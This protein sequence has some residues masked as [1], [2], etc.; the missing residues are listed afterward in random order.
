MNIFARYLPI[1]RFTTFMHPSL[2][3]L[4]AHTRLILLVQLLCLCGMGVVGCHIISTPELLTGESEAGDLKDSNEQIEWKEK[5]T[6]CQISS[7]KNSVSNSTFM[8]WWEGHWQIDQPR[9]S[10]QL[11]RT[12]KSNAQDPDIRLISESL[13]EAFALKIKAQQASLSVDGEY[14]RLATTPLRGDR[15][16]RLVG[17]KRD[18]TIWCEGEQA[19][20]RSE[21][22]ESFPL[23]PLQ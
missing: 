19:F 2:L 20:W 3:E 7:R 21:S 6:Q 12:M 16:V 22:G 11:A 18:I 15:G 9:L 8:A 4:Q 14:H 23:R 13:A 17:G 1:F 5:N 10:E